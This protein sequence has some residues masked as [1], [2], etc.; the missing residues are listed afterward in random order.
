MISKYFAFVYP[1]AML[2]HLF[3]ELSGKDGAFGAPLEHPFITCWYP[4]GTASL[5]LLQSNPS[6]FLGVLLEI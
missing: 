2:E 3:R 5:A 1:S 6:P 4:T